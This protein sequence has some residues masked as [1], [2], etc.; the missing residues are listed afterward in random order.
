MITKL[1]EISNEFQRVEL[2]SVLIIVFLKKIKK[3]V[4]HQPGDKS[5][6]TLINFRY[7]F[8]LCAFLYLI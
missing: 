4:E 5:F 3:Q 8:A 1:K 6:A 2:Y 7:Y